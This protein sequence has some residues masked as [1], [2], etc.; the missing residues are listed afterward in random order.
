LSYNVCRRIGTLAPLPINLFRMYF[1][2]C[3]LFEF[4]ARGP[5]DYW[6]YA[7]WN[8]LASCPPVY[9][10]RYLTVL[11]KYT[12]IFDGDMESLVPSLTKYVYIN[13]FSQPG[14]PANIYTLFN[15]TGKDFYGP[16]LSAKPGFHYRDLFTEQVLPVVDG[17]VSLPILSAKLG[18]IGEFPGE[19]PA[20]AVMA[21]PPPQAAAAPVAAA[22]VAQAPAKEIKDI[23]DVDTNF[24][25]EKFQDET[26]E[27]RNVFADPVFEIT[28]FPWW[29]P[30]EPFHRLPLENGFS[31]TLN[32]LSCHTSGG[33]VRFT[34]NSRRI[35]LR[36]KLKMAWESNHMARTGKFGFDFYLQAGTGKDYCFRNIA[37]GRE[38]MNGKI[39]ESWVFHP[40]IKSEKGN[41]ITWTLYLPSYCGEDMLEL[42]FEPGAEFKENKPLRIGK[43]IVFYGSSITQGGCA[44]RTGNKYT[45]ML[46][47]V[48]DA[49]EI[50]LGFSGSA[51]GEEEMAKLIATLD[52]SAFVLDYDYNSPSAEHL[53]ATHAK[54]FNIVRQA[55]PDLPI[56]ILSRCTLY[57][58]DRTAVI[59][60]TYEDAVQAGD[61]H[62]WFV[63]GSTLIDQE[64]K[65][66]AS[67]DG[68]H[69]ND[70]GFFCMYRNLLPLFAEIFNRPDLLK[71]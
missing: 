57:S 70:L 43:P 65:V 1:P 34:T 11:N 41:F 4:N 44:T 38:E 59:R 56:I 26:L 15:M 21:E 9:P 24:K 63:D 53:A 55:H 13:R 2:E 28:G 3:K 23:S 33:M 48:L 68:C 35:A 10:W 46:C 17:K 8:G 71:K 5:E 66:A 6:E 62:V 25:S 49:P 50:N 51:R 47:R 60:K 27:F 22:V 67:V 61:K 30:G 42:G 58:D 36:S 19:P 16:V 45:T 32:N 20:D 69:P 14:N 64:A 52:M 31:K 40:E 7:M 39:L 29:K 37:G 54:F 12:D 18:V